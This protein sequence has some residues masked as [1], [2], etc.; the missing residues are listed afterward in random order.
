MVVLSGYDTVK[1]ALMNQADAFAGR[2]KIPNTEE[3]GKGKGERALL[4]PIRLPSAKKNE[5]FSMERRMQN[6][7]LCFA[8][9]V[10]QRK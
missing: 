3:T 4:F 10:R 8:K 2:P 7:S 1:E 5:T 9:H 6:V